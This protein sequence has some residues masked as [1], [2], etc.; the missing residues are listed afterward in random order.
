M[1]VQK[2]SASKLLDRTYVEV[3]LDGKAGKLSRKEAIAMFAQEM[4]VGPE[5]VGIVRLEEHT[6]TRKVLGKFYVYGSE[7]SLK[8]EH[9]K[10][11][12][13]RALTKEEREKIKQEKKKAATAA[14]ATEAKK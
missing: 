10:Y 14:T 11:L 2:K 5:K 9:P 1:Q 4:G 6:G 7:G 12:Q 3:A 8:S 13:L